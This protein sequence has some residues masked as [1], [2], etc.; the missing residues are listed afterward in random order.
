MTRASESFYYD[1]KPLPRLGIEDLDL[2][3][4]QYYLKKTEQD[5][6]G[7]DNQR[8]LRSWRLLA[9]DHPT[10][11]GLVLFGKAPQEHLPFAQ[12]N[13]FRFPGT[14]SSGDPS[15]GKELKGQLLEVIDQAERFLNLHLPIPRQI[16]GF[17]PEAKPE[18]PSAALREAVVN[19][20]AH[21]DYTVQGA[22]RLL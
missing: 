10:I 2:Y 3:A 4:F 9:G 20:V 22:S 8:L 16:R 18:L 6:L 7:I 14:D 1:E 5:N 21:R 12:V 17:E 19:A 11:A 15:D 13:A